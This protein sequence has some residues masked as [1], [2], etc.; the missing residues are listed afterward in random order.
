M[1][2]P[3]PS[4]SPASGGKRV[5]GVDGTAAQRRARF[6]SE[7]MYAGKAVH[8]SN[9]THWRVELYVNR[10][11]KEAL[12]AIKAQPGLKANAYLRELLKPWARVDAEFMQECLQQPLEDLAFH[13]QN[14]AT[15]DP[16]NIYTRQLVRDLSGVIAQSDRS[17]E[18][19][20]AEVQ[21]FLERF[22]SRTLQKTLDAFEEQLQNNLQALE[23]DGD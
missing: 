18:F 13:L 22:L 10:Q 16:C 9:Q 17:A 7:M 2:K 1:T 20:V 3:K 11:Q 21:Y 19:V 12:D 5:R 6:T 4:P 8:A 23:L 14:I 15:T